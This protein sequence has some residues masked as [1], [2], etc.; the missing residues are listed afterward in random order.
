MA[1]VAQ[2]RT[3][4]DAQPLIDTLAESQVEVEAETVGDTLR[5]A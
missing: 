1:A 2:G 4:S 3:A 5:Y